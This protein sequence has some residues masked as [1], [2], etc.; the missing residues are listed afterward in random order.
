MEKKFELIK[1][2]SI[3]VEGHTLYRIRALKDFGDQEKGIYQVEKGMLG[4]YI[5]K[6]E[7]LSH[8]G[9]C[10]VF[11]DAKVFGDAV[12][13]DNAFVTDESMVFGNATVKGRALLV[14]KS[15][16]YGF[17]IIQDDA[18]V[19]NRAEVFE[20]AIMLNYSSIDGNAKL[21]GSAKAEDDCVILGFAEVYGY[22]RVRGGSVVGGD[23]KVYGNAII[24]GQACITDHASVK[25]NGIVSGRV[26]MCGHATV[27]KNGKVF[28]VGRID[29]NI[30]GDNDVAVYSDPIN[31]NHYITAS[32]KEDWF[33]CI[34]YS[35][36]Q[37]D[38]LGEAKKR[39]QEEFDKYSKITNMHLDLYD[40]R[41]KDT[42]P[43]TVRKILDSHR[44]AFDALGK[45]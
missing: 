41:Q 36:D 14:D 45:K 39:N 7:N 5:Q 32:T 37:K 25:N 16:V 30:T 21:Y 29:F 40:L 2:D 13:K 17:A 15:K 19:M 11:D 44:D 34:N 31:K 35:G 20:R 18:V 6:E 26:I 3:E 4:G 10:W 42:M 23:S 28:G 9:N 43:N 12:V 1:E 38:L 33:T 8:E 24:N 27:S 22:A